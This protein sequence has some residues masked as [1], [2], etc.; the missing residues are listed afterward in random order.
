ME[1]LTGRNHRA[2]ARSIFKKE[3]TVISIDRNESAVPIS[4]PMRG[5]IFAVLLCAAILAV[6]VV[7]I[8]KLYGLL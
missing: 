5:N 4:H 2:V 7:I 3:G 1:T 8:L 6:L